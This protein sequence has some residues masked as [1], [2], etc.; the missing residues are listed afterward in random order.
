MVEYNENN[1]FP[2]HS[3]SKSVAICT[4]DH[5]DMYELDF[6]FNRVVERFPELDPRPFYREIEDIQS[7]KERVRTKHLKDVTDRLLRAIKVCLMDEDFVH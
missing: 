1:R 2:F 6:I 5:E 3:G 4:D 7:M